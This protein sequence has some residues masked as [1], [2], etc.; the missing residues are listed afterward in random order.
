[1]ICEWSL[2]K[3]QIEKIS[4]LSNVTQSE[5]S[6]ECGVTAEPYDNT[7]GCVEKKVSVLYKRKPCKANIAF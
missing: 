7:L 2:K 5:I 1:M 3:A 6:E 4:D